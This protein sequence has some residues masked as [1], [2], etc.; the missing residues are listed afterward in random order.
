MMISYVVELKFCPLFNG[1]WSSADKNILID[2]CS[3]SWEIPTE[4]RNLT[5]QILSR[6][7][8]IIEFIILNCFLVWLLWSSDMDIVLKRYVLLLV[9]EDMRRKL[10]FLLGKFFLFHPV[11]LCRMRLVFLRSHARCGPLYLWWVTSPKGKLSWYVFFAWFDSNFLGNKNS[12][13]HN[14]HFILKEKCTQHKFH[15]HYI[16]WVLYLGL[17]MIR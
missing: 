1:W 6:G 9:E 13:K 5:C 3:C 7:L 11:F 8:K 17:L 10:L 15:I 2:W 16:W 4:I 12:C 14:F